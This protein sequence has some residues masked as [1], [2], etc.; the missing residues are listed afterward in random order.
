MY[1]KLWN[2]Y[3]QQQKRRN[4]TKNVIKVGGILSGVGSLIGVAAHSLGET[5]RKIRLMERHPEILEKVMREYGE[6]EWTNKH[7]EAFDNY[8]KQHVDSLK[9][10]MRKRRK[11]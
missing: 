9:E 4:T 8:Y 3:T 10:V 6:D 11:K 1:N 5:R 2:V 7:E